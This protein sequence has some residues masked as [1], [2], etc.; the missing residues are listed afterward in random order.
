M[1]DEEK[2]AEL[3]DIAIRHGVRRKVDGVEAFVAGSDVATSRFANNGMTQNQAPQH[4]DISVR[5]QKNG[6]QARLSSDRISPAAIRELVDNAIAAASYLEPDDE[7]LPMPKPEKRTV[8]K[9]VNRYDAR[10]A[11]FTAAQRA[12]GIKAMIEVAKERDLT[13][14]GIFE[15]GSFAEAIGNS[16][17]LFRFHRETTAEVSVTMKLATGDQGGESTGWAKA[18]SPRAADVD[19][20]GLAR[21]AAEKAVASANPEEIAPGKYTVIL[22][23]SAVLD[24]LCFIDYDFTGTSF[25]DQLSCFLNKLGKPVVGKNIQISDDVFH[26]LQSGPPF[27]GEGLQRQKVD[28]VN[29][30]ILQHLVYGRRS[31]AELGEKSTGHGLSE[32]NAEGEQPQNI[33]IGGGTTSLDDMIRSTERGVLLTR[34]W[35]VRE[36]DPTSKIVTGMT[37]DGTFLVENGAIKCGIKNMRFN[38]SLLGMLKN[39]VALGPAIRAAGEEGEPAVL[40]AMKVENFNFSSV[41]TF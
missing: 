12:Q 11:K 15:T 7:M 41:T 32:P 37:R 9:N 22:E 36:V 10:T 5:V 14:A 25:L 30:G 17:G 4:V 27:D 28:L 21:R 20:E 31:A 13:A 23:P 6:R 16:E 35:Y 39:V 1:L 40:P 3:I 34:V 26:P 19:A 8:V 24:L 18:Q 33:V 29:G 38:E 2:A